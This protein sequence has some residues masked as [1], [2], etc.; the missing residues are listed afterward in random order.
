MTNGEVEKKL[1]DAFSMNMARTSHILE[2]RLEKLGLEKFNVQDRHFFIKIQ[3][4]D[5]IDLTRLRKIIGTNAKLGFYKTFN[6]AD[7]WR[8][9]DK[10]NHAVAELPGPHDSTYYK[11]EDSLQHAEPDRNPLL[12]IVHPNIIQDQRGQY[13]WPSGAMIGVIEAKDTSLFNS[14]LKRIDF[15]RYFI[16]PDLA[17]M[18]GNPERDKTKFLG[19]Y[20][21]RTFD[22]YRP[23]IS[24]MDVSE[25]HMVQD[26]QIGGR[27]LVTMTFN[28]EATEKWQNLTREE[29]GKAI[30]IV[31]DGYVY[32]APIVAG[33]IPN[34][35]ST[36]SGNFSM[37]E[38][39]DLANLLKAGAY[40]LFTK[41][42]GEKKVKPK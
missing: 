13:T 27:P 3:V 17:F 41:I 28:G 21:I 35:M 20:C 10:L 34:G 26:E 25:A 14:Y 37:D 15:A 24:G 22:I 16:S 5:P 38:A 36:I 11:G 32:S 9:F 2:T 1:M 23:E 33:E 19:I 31:L 39:T 12:K 30:A 40:P 4:G 6:A 18:Y 7:A 42:T 8:D 29:K